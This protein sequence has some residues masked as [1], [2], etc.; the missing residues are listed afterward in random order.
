MAELDNAAEPRLLRVREEEARTISAETTAY[1]AELALKLHEAHNFTHACATD[2]SLLPAPDPRL[3]NKV[4]WGVYL[5][6]SDGT[7]DTWGGA[8]PTESSSQDA[9]T[10]ALV[11]CVE[12]ASKEGIDSGDPSRLLALIDSRPVGQSVDAAWKAGSPQA[13]R[14]R[15][16]REDMEQI[17][18]AKRD[19]L[20]SLK[21][22]WIPS[23]VGIIPNAY[24]D[25]IADAHR[26]D[27]PK[28]T[29]P[30][31]GSCL[32]R[33]AKLENGNHGAG[34]ANGIFSTTAGARP[35]HTTW[36]ET[37]SRGGSP[38]VLR[39]TTTP[40]TGDPETYLDSTGT[41]IGDRISCS[42]GGRLAN[43]Q[44]SSASPARVARASTVPLTPLNSEP[45]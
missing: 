29:Y 14:A 25:A 22:L 23:H 38:S 7:Y 18:L 30:S 40:A 44:Q 37:A 19:K 36:P 27:A 15:P 21:L 33:Y 20:E 35:V 31:P 28:D 8:L 4:A 24:A 12:R 16:R 6:R 1:V 11:E 32:V 45:S 26:F 2:G 17:A 13:I 34:R 42:P 41:E 39:V 9:E 10:K 5:T 43:G 3:T